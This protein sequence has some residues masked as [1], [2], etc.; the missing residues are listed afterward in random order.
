METDKLI[1]REDVLRSVTVP[2]QEAN[3]KYLERIAQEQ[4]EGAAASATAAGQ[5]QAIA[6]SARD[7][8]D[9][10][11]VDAAQS[12]SDAAAS[13]VQSV[14]ARQ[15]AESARDI[16]SEQATMA[17]EK[18]SAQVSLATA[19][20]NAAAGSA[21]DAATSATAA[22]SAAADASGSA[23]GAAGSATT[24]T[25]QAATATSQ[26]GIATAQATSAA[27]NAA[28]AQ[29][30]RSGAE[31]ARDA[32]LIQ[33]GSAPDEPTGRASVGDGQTYKVQ[34]SGKIAAYEYRRITGAV[35]GQ[36][37]AVYPS[38]LAYDTVADR[39]KLKADLLPGKN[40][41]NPADPDV[42]LGSFVDPTNGST[43]ANVSYNATG[44]IPVIGGA[45]YTV[46]IKH[47]IAWYDASKVF[48]SGSSSTD[49][50]KT[51]SAPAG[52]AFLRC[53]V[54]VANWSTFQ[55][56]AG[57]SSSAFQPYAPT[58]PA[59]QLPAGGVDNGKLAAQSVSA[60]R[61]NFLLP[62]KNLFNINATDALVGYYVDSTSGGVAA[63]ASYN[64]TGFIPIAAGSTYALSVKHQIAWYDASKA[65]IAGSPS[66][67]VNKAQT[68]PAGAAYLR[69]TVP[70]ANWGSFQ[71][72]SGGA[73]TTFESFYLGFGVPGG[74]PIRLTSPLPTAFVKT[75]TLADA[76]VTPGKTSFL[77]PG[78]NLFNLNDADVA[79]GY[80][81][82]ST[83]G[84][85]EANA[86]YNATGFIPIA[87]G[88]IYT[89]SYKHHIAWYDAS[90]AFISGS[91][92]SDANKTQ[93]A[94]A[95]AVY[96]RCTVGTASWATFQ[97]EAGSSQTSYEA[98]RL[99]LKTLTVPISADVQDGGVSTAKL[100]DRAVT[101]DKASFFQTGKNKFNK[102]AATIG[103]F[104][105]ATGGLGA[106]STYDVSDFIAVTPGATYCTAY[107][108]FTCY[109]DANK[110][111]VAGGDSSAGTTF[112]PP[113]GAAYVRVTLAHSMLPT[114]QVEAGAVAT[115]Y[116]SYRYVLK[117]GAVP[118][119]P[120]PDTGGGSGSLPPE[121]VLP[122]FIYAVEGRECNVYFDN[123]MVGADSLSFDATSSSDSGQQQNERWT[124]TPAAPIQSGSISISAVDRR[125]GGTLTSKAATQ[126]AAAATA[127]AGLTKKVMVIGDSLVNAGV[128]TQTLLD[129]ATTDAMGVT[130]LGTRGSGT[131]KHEGRGGWTVA[132]YTSAGPTYRRFNVSG[133]AQL[134]AINAT[135]YSDGAG[136]IYR[137]QEI[138]ITGGAGTVDCS[139][140]S[141]PSTPAASGT[142]TKTTANAGDATLSYSATSNVTGNPFWI[143]G[144]LNFAQYLS[145]NSMAMPDWVFI[146]LGINDCFGYTDDTACSSFAD[147]ALAQL[148]AL[149]SSIKAA[150][151]N[152]K[153]GLMIP[154]PPSADQDSFGAVYRTGQTRDRFKRNILIWARQLLVKYAGQEASRVYIVPSNTALDTVNNMEVGPVLPVNSRSP[155]TKGRQSNGVHPWTTG[156][157]QIGDALWAFL[158]WFA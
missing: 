97:V 31:A 33:I 157:Q 149:I 153:V 67:D 147:S 57:T 13:A 122:P 79:I 73:P 136:T 4:A 115:A 116:E 22:G 58:M 141:G 41:F 133:V 103:Y 80:Y 101:V 34:G 52:A 91:P 120:D 63:N 128:I 39:Q 104:L 29:V 68:A 82:N 7:D 112:T 106:N 64:S 27:N 155:V 60:S 126:R 152:V 50:N 78:K 54:P 32:A 72:E 121:M 89:L 45:A 129:I 66:T 93:T 83:N 6:V 1:L 61:T 38:K 11:R 69:C 102:D 124:W 114:Y 21:G 70:V 145:N 25:S 81:V 117:G 12:K 24:A 132:Y 139:V 109:F 118:I 65:Y 10:H 77:Q 111:V 19:Q 9:A 74:A 87:G 8:A 150:G 119:F 146:A 16:A 75:T 71:V 53:T 40:L 59:A 92:L 148:D 2:E 95:N 107:F 30:A 125:S 123:L 76:A 105:S 51:Q 113:A 14:A 55:V 88:A 127:G 151:A 98:Y 37:V 47:H 86:P 142:L 100:M 85:V 43:Q 20:A 3:L 108:R 42:L 138:A 15:A 44:F 48:I 96:L 131:N 35:P 46:S 158:K 137:V 84:N 23:S 56:E 36:L 90:K 99:Q 140:V 130:L 110:T 154:T 5:A 134:P 28:A 18:G 17:E 156:Y 143:G 62:G 49:M 135:E 144:Q 26:A 94:P